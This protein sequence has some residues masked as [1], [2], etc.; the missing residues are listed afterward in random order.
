MQSYTLCNNIYNIFSKNTR[1]QQMKREFTILVNDCMP[2]IG[3]PLKTD[4]NIGFPCKQISYLSLALITPI[5]SYYSFNHIYYLLQ[6]DLDTQQRHLT[7]SN[8]RLHRKS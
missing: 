4:N 8:E 3:S 6:I 5:A 2:R 1:R 7:R